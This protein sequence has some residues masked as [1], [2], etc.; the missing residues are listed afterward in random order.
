MGLRCCHGDRRRPRRGVVFEGPAE[1]AVHRRPVGRLRK[2]QDVRHAR[3]G[4]RRGAGQRRRRQRGGRRPSRRGRAQVIRQRC[5]ARPAAGRAGQGAVAGRRHDR[6]QGAGVRPARLSRQRHAHQRRAPLLCAVRGRYVPLLR[7]L[8]HEAR[9]RDAGDIA[10]RQ[11]PEL[12]P[13]PAGRRGGA[14]HP[15]EPPDHDGGLE[16]RASSRLRQQRG[17]EAFGGD[18]AQRSPARRAAPAGGRAGRG[19]ERGPWFWRDGGR[20]A[21]IAPRRRQGRVH[22]LDRG[23]QAHRE[24]R[25]RQQPQARQP[26]A[27]RQVAQHRVRRRGPDQGGVRRFLRHL[28]QPGPDVLGRFAAVRPGKGLRRDGRFAAQDGGRGAH[29]SGHRSRDADRTARLQDA[30]GPSARLHQ[31]WQRGRGADAGRR[32]PT[33]GSG[34]REFRPAHGVR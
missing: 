13:S 19:C 32:R 18:A 15:V 23:R 16:D 25:G 17:A 27:G 1:E 10:A 3:S 20:K 34:S 24:S 14:D 28:F 6:R 33:R 22:G 11:V 26:R 12:H 7:R 29:R 2:R 4:H 9:R 5:V 8:G 30:D 31:A 21:R